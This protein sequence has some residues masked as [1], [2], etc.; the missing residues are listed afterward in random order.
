MLGMVLLL[1]IMFSVVASDIIQTCWETQCSISTVLTVNVTFIDCSIDSRIDARNVATIGKGRH[2]GGL[3]VKMDRGYHAKTR[4]FL[5]LPSAVGCI[6]LR[7]LYLNTANALSIFRIDF[8]EFAVQG[9]LPARSRVPFSTCDP[10]KVST[11]AIFSSKS[12]SLSTMKIQA[13]L[14]AA[15]W[16][17][18]CKYCPARIQL[19]KDT[20]LLSWKL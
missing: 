17:T 18:V 9:M 8:R 14:C 3:T 12:P 2:G 19:L 13:C 1:P 20:C 16:H 11:K 15:L 10:S 7:M 5:R 4:A 6:F